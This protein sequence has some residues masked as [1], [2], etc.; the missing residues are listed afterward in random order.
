MQQVLRQAVE[1]L[2]VDIETHKVSI[3]L[4]PLPVVKADEVQ[5]IQLCQNLISNSIKYRRTDEPLNIAVS[6][7]RKDDEWVFRFK[8]NGMGIERSLF[9]KIFS[10][11][12]RGYSGRR[13]GMGLGLYIC[14]RVVERHGGRMWVNARPGK[15][16][17]FYFTLPA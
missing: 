4:Y 13:E 14:K 8:D 12:Q 17:T 3:R 10:K 1:N 11:F 9:E 7:Q 2:K 5:L 15:G 16:T 6:A